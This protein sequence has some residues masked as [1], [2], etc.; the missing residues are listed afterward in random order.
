MSELVTA[1]TKA[2]FLI[3]HHAGMDGVIAWN[4]FSQRPNDGHH[5]TVQVLE[6]SLVA[7]P[8]MFPTQLKTDPNQAIIVTPLA[9]APLVFAVKNTSHIKTIQ[10][11]ITAYRTQKLNV[12]TS[13]APA[14]LMHN[15]FS[16]RIKGNENLQ[17]IPYKGILPNLTD[18]VAGSI[19]VSIVPAI[20]TKAL[21]EAGH[22]R[23]IAVADD[24]PLPFNRNIPLVNET[25]PN[26]T[27]KTTYTLFLPKDTPGEIVDWYIKNF[28]LAI[29]D[30]A[31][32]SW[33][34]DQWS[35]PFPNPSLKSSRQT[36]DRMQQLLPMAQQFLKQS[37]E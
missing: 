19:D 22:I 27:A 5:I 34:E 1:K 35:L 24:R 36:G 9:S 31:I 6:S 8:V 17:T 20:S 10:E 21:V 16:D 26:F 30:P 29:K 7:L 32:N 11:L 37:N 3:E 4:T 15:M 13:G 33:L 14:K 25:L 28:S 2:T 18:L 12:G 23:I